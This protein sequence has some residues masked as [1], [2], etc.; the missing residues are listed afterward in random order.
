MISGLIRR[1]AFTTLA[2]LAAASGTAAHA[3]PA[4]GEKPKTVKLDGEDGARVD[5]TAWSSEMIKGKIWAV[6]Y[7]DPDEKGANEEM[8]QALKKEDFPKDR[9][10]SM[11]IINM[12]AT[13]LPN[14]AIASSLESKQK[15]FPDT[16]YVKDLK[17]VLVKEWG[18]KDDD[19]DVMLFDKQGKILFAKD[20]TLGKADIEKMVSL[21]KKNLD[22][23]AK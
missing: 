2:A 10:S 7:V 6:F 13:W 15:E 4:T 3:G 9:Y 23:S 11:A 18:L 14:A 8:E 16:T 20:G 1:S 19:Y 22:S 21:I 12:A 17:K 5:G